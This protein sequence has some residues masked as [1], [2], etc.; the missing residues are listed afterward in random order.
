V[1]LR[2]FSK[3]YGLAGLRARPVLARPLTMVDA[4]A[5][6]ITRMR[7]TLRRDISRATLTVPSS[8]P[9][10]TISG[11]SREADEAVPSGTGSMRSGA[12]SGQAATVSSS[13]A[14]AAALPWMQTTK[15]YGLVSPPLQVL[16]LLGHHRLV[17]P[18][19]AVP[20]L[21]YLLLWVLAQ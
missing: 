4:R 3:A 19:L 2:T 7:S 8:P 13:T 12:I 17:T 5:D 9:L 20:D 11:S 1:S 10:A 16:Q 14:I 6:D 15:K 18:V 21:T